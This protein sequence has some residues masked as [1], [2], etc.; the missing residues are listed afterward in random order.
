VVG[1]PW[2][3]EPA[4]TKVGPARISAR[5]E[6]RHFVDVREGDVS[7]TFCDIDEE[8]DFSIIDLT[9]HRLSR[10]PAACCKL[11][12]GAVV[13]CDAIDAARKDYRDCI[14]FVQKLP[15]IADSEIQVLCAGWPNF[16]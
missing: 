9:Q 16:K 13:V 3:R 2:R 1:E 10:N 6:C 15:T 4:P 8:I 11:R 14:V 7:E 5:R 12:S